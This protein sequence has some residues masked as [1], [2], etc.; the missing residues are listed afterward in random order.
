MNTKRLSNWWLLTL[1]GIIAIVYGIIAIFIPSATLVTL[2]M[3][4]GIVILI[5]GF[6]MLW[7]AINSIRDKLPYATDLV[8]SLIT[9]AI[10]ALL[11]FYTSKSLTIFVMIIGSWAVLVGIIQLYVATKSELLPGEKNTLLINGIITLVFGIILFFNPFESAKFLVVISGILA[12]IFGIVLI[13][14]SIRLKN[15]E[16]FLE[17]QH[18]KEEE[19]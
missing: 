11:T 14:I 12:F 10:G 17:R 1:N 9:I 19:L 15:V 16:R 4:F 3:Y 18:A 7:G 8:S 6:A 2:V 5:I 13:A